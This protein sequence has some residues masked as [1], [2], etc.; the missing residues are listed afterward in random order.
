M[1]AGAALM[2]VSVPTPSPKTPLY[3]PKTNTL[4]LQVLVMDNASYPAQNATR[5]SPTPPQDDGT[6]ITTSA[7]ALLLLQRTRDNHD[8]SSGARDIHDEPSLLP[9]EANPDLYSDSDLTDLT[10]YESEEETFGAT[11]Q[12]HQ[13]I[14][15]APMPHSSQDSPGISSGP[16]ALRHQSDG[17]TD[18]TDLTKYES[19]E[20]TFRA[21]HQPHQPAS[22]VAMPS[23]SQDSH[24]ISNNP[25]CQP[26]G[27]TAPISRKQRQAAEC[28]KHSKHKKIEQCKQA[29]S[30]A[31]LPYRGCRGMSKAAI[32]HREESEPILTLYCSPSCKWTGMKVAAKTKH[33]QVLALLRSGYRYISWDGITPRPILDRNR[34]IVA[35]LCRCPTTPDWSDWHLRIFSM[36]TDLQSLARA[37]KKYH[38]HW[39]GQFL[40]LPWGICFG[41]GQQHPGHLRNNKTNHR[42]LKRFFESDEIKCLMGFID[43][44]FQLFCPKLHRIYHELRNDLVQ[45]HP[46]LIPSLPGAFLAC[47]VN[48]GPHTCP[49]AHTDWKNHANSMCPTTA[50]GNFDPDKGGE[51]VLH[52]LKLIIRFPP[53]S[54]MAFMSANIGHEI[55]PIQP[56]EKRFSIAQFSASGLWRWVHNGF[57][58]DIDFLAQASLE[59]QQTWRHFR[60]HE[61]WDQMLEE[62]QVWNM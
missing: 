12:P 58:S 21:T 7:Q 35:V 23:G 22:A 10:E 57:M 19:E 51:M 16:H 9:L 26:D 25:P 29:K 61:L 52:D 49:V 4:I 36:L 47:H 28:N 20:E 32:K 17:P 6:A 34:R 13:P 56:N 41:R 46:N 2:A 18:L 55:I 39:H 62:M 44:S 48:L 42:L 59:E 3:Q 33:S 60:D 1:A 45:H 50:I 30:L 38:D 5:P 53:A 40:T 31:N 54:S 14:S 27:P 11:H 15:A 37:S 8:T 24:R 43:Q